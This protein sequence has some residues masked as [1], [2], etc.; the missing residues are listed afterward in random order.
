MTSL[1]Y[2][3]SQK[4]PFKFV[5]NVVAGFHCSAEQVVDGDAI[6]LCALRINEV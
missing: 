3:G 6:T 4:F 1:T 5:V 2:K